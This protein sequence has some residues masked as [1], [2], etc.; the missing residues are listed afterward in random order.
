MTET[1]KWSGDGFT[2]KWVRIHEEDWW[3]VYPWSR[4]VV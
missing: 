3:T 4:G 2:A 1:E